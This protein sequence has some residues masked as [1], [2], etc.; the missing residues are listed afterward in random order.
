MDNKIREFLLSSAEARIAA[1]VCGDGYLCLYKR[2][3]SAAELLKH[4]RKNIYRNIFLI[5]YCN[6]E[7]VLL[8]MFEID[9]LKVYGLKTQFQKGNTLS[10]VA[11][12]VFQRIQSFGGGSSRSWFVSKEVFKADKEIVVEWLKAF[13]DDEAHVD[14]LRKR[15]VVNSVNEVGLRQVQKLLK[16]VGVLYTKFYGPYF[17]KKCKFYRLTIFKDS[18]KDYA[19]TIGFYH[20]KKV[21]ELKTMLGNL[22]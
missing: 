1:H 10:F 8:R 16:S 17:Y 11:K 12:W 22:Y 14:L 13:F 5:G 21:N 7:S 2:K 20:P 18:I 6:T 15:I 19:E 9:V 3:R 4:S